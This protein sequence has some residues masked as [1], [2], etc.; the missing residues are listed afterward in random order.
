MLDVIT[1]LRNCLNL[2]KIIIVI[3]MGKLK[4][5]AY[6]KIN[7][8]IKNSGFIIEIFVM[9]RKSGLDAVPAFL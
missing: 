8:D 3:I 1:V 5:W 7:H 6:S 9:I 4:K 2:G